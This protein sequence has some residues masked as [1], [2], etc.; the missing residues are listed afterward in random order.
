MKQLLGSLLRWI[1]LGRELDTLRREHNELSRTVN[2][3][4][5]Q[6]E[7][8]AAELRHREEVRRL[9]G[10]QLRGWLEQQIAKGPPQLPASPPASGKAVPRRR[11]RSK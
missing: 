6:V 7:L 2:R 9:E 5:V 10:G 3:L 11:K 8:L 1:A 4:I